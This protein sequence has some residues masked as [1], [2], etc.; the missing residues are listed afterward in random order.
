MGKPG[1]ATLAVALLLF[2]LAAIVFRSAGAGSVVLDSEKVFM[3]GLHNSLGDLD[4]AKQQWVEEKNKSENDIPTMTD[5][6]PYLGDRTNRI[7]RF[8]AMGINYQITAIFD[9]EPQSDIATLTRDVRFRRGIC[10]FYPAGTRYSLRHG[11]ARPKFNGSLFQAHDV[12][13]RELLAAAMFMVGIGTLLVFVVRK[14]RHFRQRS[15]VAN[16]RQNP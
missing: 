6:T 15:S 12:Y 2:L 8:I 11:W 3:A 9:P 7:E 16:E 13:H 10:R 14:I 4:V 1:Y 5:L